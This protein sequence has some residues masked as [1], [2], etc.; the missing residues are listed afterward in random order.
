M[1]A[2]DTNPVAVAQLDDEISLRDLFRSIWR[3]RVWAFVGLLVG[4]LAAIAVTLASYVTSPGVTTFRQEVAFMLQD[5]NGRT[6]PNGTDFSP[7]DLRAPIVLQR[8]Y[9]DLDLASYGLGYSEFAAAVSVTPASVLYANM[10]ERYRERLADRTLTFEERRQIEMEFSGAIGTTLSVNAV[11]SLLLPNNTSVPRAVGQQIVTAIPNIWADI[12]INQLGALDLP[13]ANST[14][15]LLRAD[16][17]DSLDYP[18]AYDALVT[19]FSE[20][21]ERIATV[22]NLSGSFNL[23]DPET[24]RTL[25]DIERDMN[26]LEQFSL[27]HVIA[28]LTELGLN[29]SP[30]LTIAAYQYQIEEIERQI[31]NARENAL[32][33]NAVLRSAEQE[34]AVASTDSGGQQSGAVIPNTVVQQFGPELVDRLIDMSV[35]NA[36]I[37]FRQRLLDEKLKFESERL[38]LSIE[39]DQLSQ[40]LALIRGERQLENAERLSEIFTDETNKLVGDLNALWSQI[41]NILAQVNSQRL[42]YDK[43]L[44]KP[45]PTV[46]AVQDSSDV[47]SRTTLFV[48][49]AA[50]GLGLLLGMMFYFGRRALRPS[51]N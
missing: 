41:D 43:Q 47:L 20:L 2:H 21:R 4:A 32:A 38:A 50:G 37:G 14:D 39:R 6:Y 15:T 19:A 28:P 26:R 24:G 7:N 1:N 17:L 16:F 22:Q 36:G 8:V 31:R 44:F 9:E 23:F 5:Q 46:N 27:L 40:R 45:I 11:V 25:F 48:W 3:S 51:F 33:I 34:G 29:K 18:I 10:I 13:I 42:N 12:Y 49:A 30:E 35:E